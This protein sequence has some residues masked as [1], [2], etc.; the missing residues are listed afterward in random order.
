[1]PNRLLAVTYGCPF[2]EMRMK[3]ENV[4]EHFPANTSCPGDVGV[5]G[6][7]RGGRQLVP[8][9]VLNLKW[10]ASRVGEGGISPDLKQPNSL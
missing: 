1:M 7:R 2:A 5:G 3:L 10:E 8:F 9:V 4:L 6:D